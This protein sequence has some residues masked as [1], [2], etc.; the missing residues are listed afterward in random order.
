MNRGEEQI[1]EFEEFRLDAGKRLLIQ[2][3][4]EPVPL[5][6]KAF[7]ILLYLVKKAGTV[8][9]KEELMEAIWPDTAVEENN[10]TQNISALRRVLGEKHRENRFI[11]T[12]PGRGYKFV[13]EVRK[14][15]SVETAW[16]SANGPSARNGRQKKP[17]SGKPWTL[18]IAAASIVVIAGRRLLPLFREFQKAA[19]AFEQVTCCI[20][21]QTRY[22]RQ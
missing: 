2:E 18:G 7:E 12:V 22:H 5:M 14:V 3:D 21:V 11:A 17:G 9:E 8:A 1:Y 16:S 4:G 19:R 20:T 15:A 6:P 10:L 13:A